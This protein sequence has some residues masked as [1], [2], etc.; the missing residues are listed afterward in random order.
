MQY[1]YNKLVVVIYIN[2]KRTSVCRYFRHVPEQTDLHLVSAMVTHPNNML[3][4]VLH[5]VFVV[6]LPKKSFLCVC[7]LLK[8]DPK[9]E[10]ALELSI[11][12]S[13]V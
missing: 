2:Y 1:I 12:F 10:T 6:L 8:Q 9:L 13:R 4:V 5:F 11:K 7:L 3:R